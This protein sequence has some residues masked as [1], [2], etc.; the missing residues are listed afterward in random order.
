MVA[1]GNSKRFIEENKIEETRLRLVRKLQLFIEEIISAQTKR[2][3][4]KKF[5]VYSISFRK[6]CQHNK[7]IKKINKIKEAFNIYLATF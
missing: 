6:E 2:Y 4:S 5:L 1:E 3:L 7:I